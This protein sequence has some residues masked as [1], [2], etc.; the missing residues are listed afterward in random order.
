MVLAILLF[1]AAFVLTCGTLA[2]AASSKRIQSKGFVVALNTFQ[3]VVI[4]VLA[5]VALL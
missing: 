3:I 5:G 2:I 1:I 4:M